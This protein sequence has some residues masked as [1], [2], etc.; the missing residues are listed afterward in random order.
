MHCYSVCVE[1][2]LKPAGG[3]ADIPKPEHVFLFKSQLE[4]ILCT[5]QNRRL[6]MENTVKTVCFLSLN[7]TLTGKS[8]PV[9]MQ[10]KVHN[11]VGKYSN[12]TSPGPKVYKVH[13]G[14]DWMTR[15]PG[16]V[17]KCWERVNLFQ[18][19]RYSCDNVRPG[20][21]HKHLQTTVVLFMA[22]V[23]CNVH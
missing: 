3:Q 6:H 16:P 5:L 1:Y 22:R 8:K 2:T 7:H 12:K 14:T 19:V 13:S 9:N 15:T 21:T 18:L 20:L 11:H 10:Q 4:S 23:V 17:A